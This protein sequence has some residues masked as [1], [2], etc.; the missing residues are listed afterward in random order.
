MNILV[1]YIQFGIG[2]ILQGISFAISANAKDIKAAWDFVQ[3]FY[4]KEAQTY[5]DMEYPFQIGAD[6]FSVRK[7][8]FKEQFRKIKKNLNKNIS[9]KEVEKFQDYVEN[10]DRSIE[11]AYNDV[12]NIVWEEVQTYY[13]KEKSLEEMLNILENR[14]NLYTKEKR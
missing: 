10:A 4:S 12:S 14:L 11:Q 1:D 9:G 2:H 3:S 6:G 5:N 8:V 13:N 7:D